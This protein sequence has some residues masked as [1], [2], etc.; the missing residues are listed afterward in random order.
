MV[1]HSHMLNPRAFLEDCIRYAKM[2]LWHS[3]FPWNITN[4][5][6][7]NDTMLYSPTDASRVRFENATDLHWNNLDDSPDKTVE[8]PSCANSVS[9]PWTAGHIETPENGFEKCHGFS[10][11]AFSFPCPSCDITIDHE[12]LKIKKFRNDLHALLQE[13]RPMPGT[14]YNLRGVPETALDFTYH[15]PSFPNRFL[16]AANKSVVGITKL[17]QCTTVADLRR[18]LE[19]RMNDKDILRE[20]SGGE[21]RLGWGETPQLN[22][23]RIRS[24]LLGEEKVSFRRMMSRYWD[25]ATPF[26]LDLVGAVTRQ[27]V[28]VRKMDDIDWLHSPT[29]MS[30]MERLIKKYRIFLDIMM[31]HP[32]NLAVPTLDVDLAW[33][34][35]QLTPSRYYHFCLFKT[36]QKTG[37][38][39]FIDH[40]D[41]VDEN[42]LSDG[43]EWTSKMYRKLT[44]GGIY[45]ECTCWYCQAVIESDVGGRSILTTPSR[46]RARN[47]ADNLHT[48]TSSD[49]NKSPHVSAHNAVQ[50]QRPPG[51]DPNLPRIK[52][53][54]TR[55]KYGK[56]RRRAEKQDRK[57]G[58][59]AD[60]EKDE[61][62]VYSWALVWGYPL[63]MPLY[64]PF[65]ADPGVHADVYASNPG[66]M[67]FVDGAA[68]N[69]AAGTCGGSV[70]AGGCG[71]LG[72]SG[73]CSGG[74]AGGS[75]GAAACAGGAGCTGGVGGGCVSGGGGCGGGGGF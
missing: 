26:A 28:F 25:N 38:S 23:M 75:G 45:S 5:S 47:A 10:D 67:S 65:M 34:T 52:A 3:G 73:S 72:A 46:S 14:Y 22:G 53:M 74:C 44:K 19:T 37:R 61:S 71:G 66:C 40:D 59:K 55:N 68:G 13:R 70:A 11:K 69:C 60:T 58:K 64:L 6:I 62:D 56:A 51:A 57:H 33:H 27:G 30:T 43:F 31:E 29:V 36:G 9:V 2:S 12:K 41:K 1:W 21:I 54:L 18:E 32:R 49:P 63:F 24:S 4:D 7:H 50:P 35:H 42:T 39:Y 20:A 17:N 15:Q 8:C 16:W 48:S